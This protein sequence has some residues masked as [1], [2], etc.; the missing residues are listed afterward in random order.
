MNIVPEAYRDLVSDE[1]K[2]IAYL[3]TTLSD[4]SPILTPIWFGVIDEHICFFTGKDTLKARN[5]MARPQV[6]IVLQDPDDIYRYIQ[7]RGRY[8][9][10]ESDGAREWLDELSIRYIG[11]KY[12]DDASSDGAILYIKPERVNVFGW[13]AE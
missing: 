10:Y 3:A 4:G 11:R 7:I 5:M 9:K 6:A 13:S 8:V 2:A 1:S 12:V